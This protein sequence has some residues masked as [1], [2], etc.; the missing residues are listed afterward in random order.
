M[1]LYENAWPNNYEEIKTWYPVWYREVLEM[2]ALWRVWGKHTDDIQAGI[3]Q[4]IDNNFIDYADAQTIS[5]LEKFFG[6]VYDGPRTL[7]ERRNVI[8][9]FIIGSGRI[10]QRQIKELISVFVDG[11]IEVQLI[12]G[13]IHIAINRED[14]AKFNVNDCYSLL[15]GRIPAHLSLKMTMRRDLPAAH[16][17]V[18]NRKGGIGYF[19]KV[20]LDLN[21]HFNYNLD[22]EIGIAP[23]ISIYQRTTLN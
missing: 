20:I 16:V 8:K 1:L 15:S 14:S 12:G 10:G 5:K 11:E 3:I 9:A 7:V 21:L 23:A 19:R 4:A 17:D 18:R 13:A 2:D 6:I 22:G